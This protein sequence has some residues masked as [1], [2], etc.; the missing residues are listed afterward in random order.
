MPDR[1]QRKRHE[2]AADW[3]L[4]QDGKLSAAEA[5][6][7]ETWLQS[8]TENRLA[9][10]AARRL[11][12]DA[13]Q[14]IS[15]DPALHDIG[16]APRRGA[17]PVVA[18]VA[19]MV[20]AGA[21]FTWLDLPM[22][23]RADHISG[24]GEL[25]VMT[26]EDG[27]RLQMNA[28]SAVA[29]DFDD[30]GRVVRL[31][32]GEAYFEVA[33]DPGRPFVVEAENVRVTALGTAFNVRLDADRTEVTVTQHSVR[34]QAAGR[35]DVESIISEGE[36]ADFDVATGVV[37]TV[38]SDGLAALAWRRGQLVVDNAS[39]GFVI[40]EINRHFSGRIF[41]VGDELAQRRVS[42]TLDI[43][44]TEAALAFLQQAL[45]LRLSRAGPL[46]LVRG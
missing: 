40:G 38:P 26:L 31:L 27:S 24:A 19:A 41:V 45:Q 43:A 11:M 15:S 4:R 25:P 32:R 10:Q 42:G 12:G 34:L 28:S 46:V 37:A 3:V 5:I 18:T 33:R 6:E 22:Y 30:S 17:G 8:S 13:Q 7:L 20:L 39:L 2:T 23:L 16:I 29:F 36:R 35:P 9:W 21:L 1:S 14:A 44:D